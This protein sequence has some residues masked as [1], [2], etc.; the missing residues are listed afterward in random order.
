MSR[1]G[2]GAGAHRTNRK[3]SAAYSVVLGTARAAEQCHQWLVVSYFQVKSHRQHAT[4]LTADIISEWNQEIW[5]LIISSEQSKLN[6]QR[7][8]NSSFHFRCWIFKCDKGPSIKCVR[9]FFGL[10]DPPP[11]LSANSLNLPYWALVL[12]PL[13][14]MPSSPL[15]VDVLNGWPLSGNTHKTY[16]T[17]AMRVGGRRLLGCANETEG[18]GGGEIQKICR[19]HFRLDPHMVILWNFHLW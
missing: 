7:S 12:C 5:I 13:L 8:E 14:G 15:C 17:S 19:R 18:Q 16:V 3:A 2:P 11:P 10:L 6:C 4:W 1:S 9:K